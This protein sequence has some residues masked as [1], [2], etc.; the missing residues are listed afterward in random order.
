MSKFL[1]VLGRVFMSVIFI[2]SGVHKFLDWKNTENGVTK[3]L[4]DWS[5]RTADMDFLQT[6]FI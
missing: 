3:I 5:Q 6:F 1:T 4:S 2:S